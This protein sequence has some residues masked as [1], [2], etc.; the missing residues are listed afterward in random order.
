MICP[1][2]EKKMEFGGGKNRSLSP[3]VDRLIPKKGYVKGNVSWVSL[4]ANLVKN[5][6][7]STELRMIAD[8]IE[9]QEIYK[10]YG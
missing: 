1:I 8:W 3:S 9:R 10:E 7:T 5:E 4:L 6:R 2:L